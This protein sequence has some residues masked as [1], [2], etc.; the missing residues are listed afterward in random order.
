VTA[1]PRRD[2][3]RLEAEIVLAFVA[4]VAAFLVA[5]LISTAARSH[6]PGTLL[7]CVFLLAI[8]AVAHY[9]GVL[10]ALPVGAVS[11]Q[12]FDWY[13]LP[14]LRVL[15]PATVLVLGLTLL[16]SVLVGALASRARGRAAASEGARSLLADEQAA[17]RRVATLVARESSPGEV[18]AAVAEEVGR[19]LGVDSTTMF[20]YEDDDTVSAVA[21][22]AAAGEHVEV[23]GR[24]PLD[25]GDPA[26]TIART[27]RP[28]RIDDYDGV[29]GRIAAFIRDELGA[30]CSVG[31]PIVVD[32]RLWGAL[33]IHSKQTVPLPAD[34]EARLEHFTELVATAIANAQARAEVQRLVDEQAA[35]RRVATLVAGESPPAEIFAAVAEELERLLGVGETTMSRYEDDGTAT[36]VA[37]GD[38]C[39]APM[40]VGTR[41]TLGGVNVATEVHRTGRPARIDDYAN[42]TGALGASVRNMGIRC[43][44][45]CP[46]VVDGRL[47]GCMIVGSRQA[48]PMPA[49]TESRIAK[50]TELVATAIS[51]IQARSDLAASRARIV[52][53]TDEERRRVVRDLHD[54]AQQR[55]V[56]TIVTLK[57]AHKALQNGAETAPGLVAE[58]L[59]HAQQATTEL[60][61]LSHGILPS[62]LTHRGLHAGVDALASRMPVP[63]DNA[64][65]VDRLPAAVEATAYFVVAEA[66]TNLAK[67]SHA[68]RAAVTARVADGKLQLQVRDDGVGGAE[69]EGSGLLGLGDRLAVLDG[70][71]RVE[72][73]ADGGTL[74]AA[75]IPLPATLEVAEAGPD[76]PG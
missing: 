76:R 70:S 16:M 23:G 36:A 24:W 8:L 10:Y 35:L 50:F 75:T 28:A 19:L 60:R 15:D 17:L 12:A 45:G 41:L 43:A 47:W 68:H 13:F 2:P 64:V 65:S 32:G 62:V 52:A 40:P 14:P 31:S 27:G 63:V 4:G 66:L 21:T 71:L 1:W 26:V 18:F 73:P 37:A 69:P 5:S 9:G 55:L 59:D 29:P 57:R 49:G 67:H 44:V 3:R 74:V 7:A 53:A 11:I 33:F 58:A 48:G 54:G 22:W 6:V 20:R 51:N 72:S 39:E 34:S 56:H 30:G 46:I 25:G 42:A 61:E 38:Q